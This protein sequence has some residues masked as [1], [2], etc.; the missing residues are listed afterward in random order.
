MRK[1]LITI[2]MTICLLCL[3]ACGS[4]T[5]T[6]EQPE[7]VEA[8]DAVAE[9][10]ANV[11]ATEAAKAEEAKAAEDARATEAAKAEEAKAA[12]DAKATEAAKAEEEAAETTETANAEADGVDTAKIEK[13]D[14]PKKMFVQK[15]V[16]VRKGPSTKFD[17]VDHYEINTEVSVVGRY[18]KDGWYMIEYKGGNAFISDDFLAETEVDLEALKAEQEA[19]ALAAIEQQKAA[20]AQQAANPAPEQTQQAPA[21]AQPAMPPAG[22][23]FIGDSRCV[24]MQEAVGGGNSSWICENS[25]GYKWLSE[26]AI[27]RADECVGKEQR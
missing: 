3:W 7:T 4:G 20:E 24:Q 27:Q 9:D 26:N 2:L 23:L 16:N 19:A 13:Y 10:E 6:A 14:S 1:A 11:A 18:E 5:Q 25:K 21:P 8:Q 17:K 12:E 15:S 22:I